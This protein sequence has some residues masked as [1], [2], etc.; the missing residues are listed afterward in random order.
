MQAAQYKAK[1]LDSLR[2]LNLDEAKEI[3]S[4]A[5]LEIMIC[6][7]NDVLPDRTH[8]KTIAVFMKDG[9]VVRAS[10]RDPFAE[11]DES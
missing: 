9:I 3:I 10:D 11:I 1:L 5:K 2:G 7:I 4:A 8:Y 6:E